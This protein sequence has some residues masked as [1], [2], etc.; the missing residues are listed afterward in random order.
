MKT[1]ME[2]FNNYISYRQYVK[3]EWNDGYINELFADGYIVEVEYN[4]PYECENR[5]IEYRMLTEDEFNKIFN[6]ENNG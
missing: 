6:T 2:S 4:G 1:P 3:E 5:D